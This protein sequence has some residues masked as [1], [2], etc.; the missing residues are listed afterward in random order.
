MTLGQYTNLVLR[1]IFLENKTTDFS[2]PLT[3]YPSQL[4]PS[5]PKKRP[6]AAA[7]RL[8]ST[9]F[10]ILRSCVHHR[11]VTLLTQLGYDPTFASRNYQSG[12]PAS[13]GLY[14][15]DQIIAYGL[16]DGAQEESGYGN[17]F[18]RSYNPS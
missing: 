5:P 1:L 14:L 18:Y 15:S 4:T 7:H 3:E 9:G 8:I 6:S 10:A 16:Q 13:L 11:C 17:S 12:S 2:S